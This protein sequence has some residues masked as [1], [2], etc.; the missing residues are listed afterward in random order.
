MKLKLDITIDEFQANAFMAWL[1]NGINDAAIDESR[2][3]FIRLNDMYNAI[4][5]E[6][7]IVLHGHSHILGDKRK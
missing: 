6:L 5:R 3:D 1:N 2:E 4:R 7:E